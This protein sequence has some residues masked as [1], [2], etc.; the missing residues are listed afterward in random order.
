[1]KNGGKVYIDDFSNFSPSKRPKQFIYDLF[2]KFNV[3]VLDPKRVI[4]IRHPRFYQRKW[5]Y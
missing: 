5:T 1:M 2:P 3:K 4:K